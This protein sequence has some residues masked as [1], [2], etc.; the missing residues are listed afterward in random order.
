MVTYCLPMHGRIGGLDKSQICMD[1]FANFLL[2]NHFFD[3]GFEG[4]IFTWHNKW[5][6]DGYMKE[7]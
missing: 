7:T 5:G 6:G 3:L 1:N 2:T 4:A